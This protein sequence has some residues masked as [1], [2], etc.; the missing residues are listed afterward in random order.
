MNAEI[1]YYLK[2]TKDGGTWAI[3]YNL[4]NEHE[5]ALKA[6]DIEREEVPT[7]AQDSIDR[8]FGSFVASDARPYILDK[9]RSHEII[10]FNEA[11]YFPYHFHFFKTFLRDLSKLDYKYLALEGLGKGNQTSITTLKE[12]NNRYLTIAP[13]YAEMMREALACGYEIFNYDEDTGG[14][15]EKKGAQNIANFVRGKNGK[16]L[17]L[18]GYDHI[19][20]T[21]TKTYWEFA[22]AGRIKE[23][24]NTD[25]LTINQT[26][27]I[28]RSERRFEDQL[29]QNIIPEV[30]QVYLDSKG[31]SFKDPKE[32]SWYDIM[33]FHPRT[34][35][36]SGKADW[37]I[38]G[39]EKLELDLS[40]LNLTYPTQ[41]FAYSTDQTFE[42]STPYDVSEINGLDEKVNL[43]LPKGKYHI[44]V[45]N[46]TGSYRQ[47]ITVD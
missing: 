10:L 37:F 42:Q 44:I 9:A 5:K 14:E 1:D 13:V 41:V 12:L 15:R 24:M 25:P 47:S 27:F 22:L 43:Y 7:L 16:T 6:L 2:A 39:K 18:C 32:P 28:E 31:Q 8:S 35:F 3:K 26:Y 23:V 40:S 33:I 17:V 30:S 20:E 21:E 29:Y 45:H 11:H 38:E 36:T 34:R 19:K 4:V 46:A